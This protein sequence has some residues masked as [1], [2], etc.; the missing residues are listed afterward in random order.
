MIRLR[1]T[2]FLH[3]P[4]PVVCEGSCAHGPWMTT[5]SVKWP[6]T[7]IAIPRHNIILQGCPE[8]IDND[9]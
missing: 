6:S 1:T 7:L 4:I 5:V 3:D 9:A 2:R 8:L